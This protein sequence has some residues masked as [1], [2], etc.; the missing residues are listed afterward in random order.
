VSSD[1]LDE[2]EGLAIQSS[3]RAISAIESLIATWELS[4]DRPQEFEGDLVRFR[5]MHRTLSDWERRMLKSA[6][7]ANAAER[8]VLLREFSR[9]FRHFGHGAAGSPDTL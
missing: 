1:S 3:N 5:D 6:G 9:I 2:L 7:K 8:E 4:S